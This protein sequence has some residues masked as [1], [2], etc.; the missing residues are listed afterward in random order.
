MPATFL[1]NPEDAR[2][3]DV[4]GNDVVELYN[5]FG[6]IKLQ[7]VI[8][9]LVPKGVLWAGRECRDVEGKPQNTIIPDATQKIGGGSTYNTTVIRIRRR[10]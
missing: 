4:R 7:A 3:H 8:S 6:S 1:I 2:N 9:A 10:E 5:D